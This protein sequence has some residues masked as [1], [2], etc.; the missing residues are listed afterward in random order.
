MTQDRSTEISRRR[1]LARGATLGGAVWAT[2]TVTAISL[3]PAS[4]AS[5]SGEK[6]PEPPKP[7]KPPEPPEPSEPPK[8]PDDHEP[9][10]EP[11]PTPSDR[12]G[13]DVKAPEDQRDDHGPSGPDDDTTAGGLPKT[14]AGDVARTVG[15]GAALAAGGAVLYGATRANGERAGGDE[16]GSPA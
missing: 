8:P 11:T 4:A 12:H 15:I 16:H 1:V 2:P 10:R 13:P 3:S 14:G 7:P 5:P 6:P 9:T